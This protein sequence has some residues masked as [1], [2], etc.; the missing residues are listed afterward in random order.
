MDSCVKAPRAQLGS[1]E[2][3]SLTQ[4]LFA[5]RVSCVPCSSTAA[6]PCFLPK[7]RE[8][9]MQGSKADIV[10]NATAANKRRMMPKPSH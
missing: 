5:Y 8:Q 3:S 1:G 10:P 6:S 7:L 2:T 9:W 4:S